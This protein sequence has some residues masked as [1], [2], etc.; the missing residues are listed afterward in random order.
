MYGQVLCENIFHS[1]FSPFPGL[2]CLLCIFVSY[3]N[4]MS[5]A[6]PRM[7]VVS[8]CCVIVFAFCQPSFAQVGNEWI[9]FNQQYFK[10]PV[11]KQGIYRLNFAALQN[12]GFP[13]ATVDPR[14]IQIFHRGLEQS[15]YIEGQGDGQLDPSDFVEFFGQRNDGTLDVSLYE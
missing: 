11:G 3:P 10:I 4:R 9:N 5:A 13:A 6:R 1:G 7:R 15:I 8:I 2:F 12:A 14:N